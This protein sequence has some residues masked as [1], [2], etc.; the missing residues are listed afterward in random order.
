MPSAS[1][2]SPSTFGPLAHAPEDGGFLLV[3]TCARPDA[4]VAEIAA[5]VSAQ[6]PAIE[7]ALAAHGTVLFRGFALRSAE[8]FDAFVSAFAGWE[9]LSYSRSMS[10][11]V[12]KRCTE[13]IC[14]TNEG[15]SGG[16]VFHHE[17]AQTP[18]WPSRV[19]FCCERP[20]EPGDGGGTGLVSSHL[21]LERLRA[22]Y[23]EFVAKCKDVGVRYTI[24]AGP[25]QDA[26]KG[27]GRSWKSFFHA[28]GVEECE[29]KMRRGGWEWEWGAGPNGAKLGPDFLRCTTPRLDAVK[30]APGTVRECFF[31]QLIATTANA[32]EFSHVGKDGGGFDPLVDVP[33]Q[34]AINECVRFA[35]GSEVDL[36]ILLDAKR[37]CEELAVDVQWQV[38]LRA[39]EAGEGRP[40]WSGR[41]STALGA[42]EGVVWASAR[43]RALRAWCLL[44]RQSKGMRCKM[45]VSPGVYGARGLL[46]ACSLPV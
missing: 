14:T 46:Q 36:A 12:R 19:F 6:Q 3:L 28:E 1:A 23:P 26:S 33:T 43:E 37:I 9:D 18:L 40:V 20:A 22:A 30:T 34:Q 8:D 10:F 5:W 41:Y 15:K 17:Q 21:V 42:G 44:S 32:L 11:A 4:S 7:R 2:I 13:R 16:L 27:A 31:N 29:A 25:V 24:F 35:D 45:G 38:R 39:Q